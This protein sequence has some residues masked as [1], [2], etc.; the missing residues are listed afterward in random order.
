MLNKI[1][2]KLIIEPKFIEI[3]NPVKQPNKIPKE[4][5]SPQKSKKIFL[6]VLEVAPIVIK[7]AI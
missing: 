2:N 3:I 7:M 1:S 5:T 6:M 4:P